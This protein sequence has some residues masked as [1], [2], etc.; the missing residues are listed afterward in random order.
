MLPTTHPTTVSLQ[1]SAGFIL[2][3]ENATQQARH[4]EF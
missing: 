2:C 3:D 1:V 4:L